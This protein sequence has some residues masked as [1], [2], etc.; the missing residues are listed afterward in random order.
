[1]VVDPREAR[2]SLQVMLSRG[3]PYNCSYCC[4]QALRQLYP[5][6]T[7]YFRL[8]SVAHSLEVLCHL[9]REY[10]EVRH[11]WFLDNLLIA[12]K[13]WFLEFASE[14]GRQ[15]ALPY[16]LQGHF[17]HIDGEIVGALKRSGCARIGFGLESGD[18]HLRSSL[19]HRHHDNDLIRH[20]V[21]LVR[22]AG[23]AVST[24]NMIGLPTETPAQMR[25]TLTLNRQLA[26]EFGACY[27]FHPYRG[28]P[29]FQFCQERRLLKREVELDEVT[30]NFA[31]PLVRM[32]PG[33]ERY[34]IWMQKRIRFFFFRQTFKY[35]CRAY[36]RNQRG[37]ARLGVFLLAL[38]MVATAWRIY[39][40]DYSRR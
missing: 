28:T 16:H 17:E 5:A 24:F 37:W 27:F 18:E 23:I 1:M 31:R 4:N 2:N 14:Y 19:L 9:K 20:T 38:R 30:S 25:A 39:R 36:A 21:S 40:Q 33:R 26:P 10:P 7:R 13:R 8:P 22:Q 3:C 12:D 15:V 35:R 11:I 32:S 34:C 6:G 29:L